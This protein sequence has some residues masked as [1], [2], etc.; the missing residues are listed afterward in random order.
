M[1][2]IEIGAGIVLAVMTS[3]DLL[4]YIPVAAVL[5]S[6][7]ILLIV[8][9]SYEEFIKPHLHVE[10]RLRDWFLRRDWSVQMGQTPS[11]TFRLNLKSASSGY[12]VVV[13]REKRTRSDFISF[14]GLVPLHP[15]WIETLNKFTPRE[16]EV[17]YSDVRI[18]LTG[19]DLSF[20]FVRSPGGEIMWPP[21]ICVQ[22]AIPQDHT[23]SQHSVDITAKSVELSMIG[24]RDVIRRA[25]V[26]HVTSPGSTRDTGG[27]E[28]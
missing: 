27:S 12:Q 24:V 7:G 13:I 28:P 4:G 23:L 19:K 10:H 17:L 5:L 11:L 22:T 25:V 26:S 14:T 1:P 18:Y 9:G 6:F 8:H 16:R 3:F 2:R 20:E 21:Q 15:D